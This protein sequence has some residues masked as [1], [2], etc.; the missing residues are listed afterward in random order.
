MSTSPLRVALWG[1]RGMLGQA[2]YRYLSQFPQDFS[3]QTFSRP[4]WEVPP[5]PEAML[6]SLRQLTPA[7]ELIINC[8]GL[9]NKVQASEDEFQRINATWPWC[10]GEYGSQQG[11]WV[12]HA[13]TDCVFDGQTSAAGYTE[14]D[15]PTATDR[16]GRS[17]RDGELHP[18][19]TVLRLS[20]IGRDPEHHRGLVEWVQSQRGQTL[21]GFR[22]HTWNGVTCE[23]WIRIVV[24]LWR[25]GLLWHG[26]RHLVPPY[27][28]TKCQLVHDLVRICQW[29]DV[30]VQPYEDSS[31]VHRVLHTYY[32]ELSEAGEIASL[33]DQ[34]QRLAQ[35]FVTRTD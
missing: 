1:S 13:S 32:P 11:C 7:P 24:R 14:S 26:V 25:K 8:I 23:E 15:L 27:E 4:Q 34:L 17:K 19:L 6:S 16:Y 33:E 22:H 30:D 29:S 18:W 21:A 10:L 20:I 3:L 9:T 31:R 12:I 28:V 35:E 2:V 5:T